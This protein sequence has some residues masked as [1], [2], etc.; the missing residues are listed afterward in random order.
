MNMVILYIYTYTELQSI[1]NIFQSKLK[2]DLKKV[3][4]SGKI[5]VFATK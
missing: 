4:S 5:M 2:E 3:K 1:R